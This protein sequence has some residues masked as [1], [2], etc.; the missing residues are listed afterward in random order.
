MR[1]LGFAICAVMGLTLQTTVAWRFE[2]GGARPDWMLVL[3]VFFALH[4]RSEEGLLAGC[5]HASPRLRARSRHEPS[6]LRLARQQLG[7]TTGP[8]SLGRRCRHP[9]FPGWLANRAVTKLLILP[10]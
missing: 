3:V 8:L 9:V 1:W 4:T 6:Q 5:I 2:I 7:Q 10:G